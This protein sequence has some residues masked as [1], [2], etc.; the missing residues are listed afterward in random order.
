MICNGDK[1]AEITLVSSVEISKG[2]VGYTIGIENPGRNPEVT[3]LQYSQSISA[4]QGE[5]IW[6]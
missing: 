5:Q 3:R 2:R 4:N 6:E 1:A